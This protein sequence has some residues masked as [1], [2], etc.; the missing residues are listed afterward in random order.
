M[1]FCKFVIK[2]E[3]TNPGDLEIKLLN[4]IGQVIYEEGL[5]KFAGAYQ[6]TI[7][8]GKYAKG[9]YTLQLISDEGAIN[10]KIIVE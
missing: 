4:V 1:S 10:R 5:S 8:V 2:R 3:I 7:D 9:V 6:K